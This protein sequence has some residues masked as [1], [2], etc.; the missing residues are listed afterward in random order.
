MVWGE[1][2]TPS[3]CCEWFPKPTYTVLLVIRGNVTTNVA[4]IW[5]TS[6]LR[7]N[8]FLSSL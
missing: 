8:M 6:P 7:H 1:K 3:N 4:L 2:T 5:L